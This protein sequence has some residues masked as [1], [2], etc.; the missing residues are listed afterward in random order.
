MGEEGERAWRGVEGEVM[1]WFFPR[2]GIFCEKARD[3]VYGFGDGWGDGLLTW[4]G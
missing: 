4:Y 3:I 2:L 1:C